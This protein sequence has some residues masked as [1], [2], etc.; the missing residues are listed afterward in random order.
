MFDKY[1]SN[2]NNTF[3]SSELLYIV[4]SSGYLRVFYMTIKVYYRVS[5]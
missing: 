3:N 1:Y 4:D 2:I 5:K